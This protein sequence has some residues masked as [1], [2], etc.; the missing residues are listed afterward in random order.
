MKTRSLL[1]FLMLLAV[2]AC[3][4]NDRWRLDGR[5]HSNETIPATLL[6]FDGTGAVI[7]TLASGGELRGRYTLLAGEYVDIELKEAWNGSKKHRER[8]KVTDDLL[9]LRDSDGTSMRFQRDFKW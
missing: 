6:H 3:S 2:P 9:F 1:L 5:W 7:I 4:S 8:I